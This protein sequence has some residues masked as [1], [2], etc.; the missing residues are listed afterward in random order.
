MTSHFSIRTASH[1]DIP[2]LH[3]LIETSVRRVSS[4]DYSEEQIAGALHR[5]LGLDTQLIEDRTY[6]L[7]TPG[8]GPDQI[9]GCGGWSYRKTLY[10][11]DNAPVR[12]L[13][14]LDPHTD[15]ARIRAIFVHP[16]WTRQGLGTLLLQHCE[17][18]AA[19]AGFRHLAMGSTRTG[20]ALYTRE[21]YVPGEH[22]DV[23]LPNVETL[24]ILRMSK[25]L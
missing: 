21:G 11:S 25:S 8:D 23:Q 22:A 3:A 20:I 10:G 14:V 9:A 12:S 2:Q 19:S 24:G 16:N 17:R 5:V 6:F 18:A 1:A 7:A 13:T 15:A 4:K